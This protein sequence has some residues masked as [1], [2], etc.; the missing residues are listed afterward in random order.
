MSATW[1]YVWYWRARHGER[2]GEFCR[3]W[4]RCNAMNTIGVEFVDGFRTITSR[5]A[6]RKRQI[7][8]QPRVSAPLAPLPQQLDL[9]GGLH[10]LTPQAPAE[11]PEQERLFEP[12]PT[13]L[14][15]QTCMDDPE[16]KEQ[17]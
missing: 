6:V 4:A 15:G 1:P 11:E 17:R 3:I 13:Q 2:K 8:P 10:A 12:A 5:H 14:A 7:A 9:D 16:R